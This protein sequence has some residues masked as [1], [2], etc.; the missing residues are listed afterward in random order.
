[1]LERDVAAGVPLTAEDLGFKRPGT[2]LAPGDAD[3]VVGRALRAD[4]ARG[5]VLT[6]EDLQA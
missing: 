4:G 6:A 5:T 3:A 2:G 1:V